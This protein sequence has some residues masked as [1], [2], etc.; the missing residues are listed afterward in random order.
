[1]PRLGRRSSGRMGSK[2]PSRRKT[3]SSVPAPTQSSS[4]GGGLLGTIAQGFAFG[5]GSA[6]AHRTIG[7]V[8]DSFSGS[9]DEEAPQQTQ[10]SH[11]ETL[12]SC[13]FDQQNFY[14]CLQRNTGDVDICND[15]FRTLQ[16]CQQQS[17]F[18]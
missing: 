8:A 18:V 6:I 15:L 13:D 3:T 1:M 17:K 12:N 5:T 2:V 10:Q 4:G 11:Q 16:Q 9:G 7:A 14:Q